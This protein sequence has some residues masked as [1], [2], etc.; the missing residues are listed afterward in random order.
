MYTGEKNVECGTTRRGCGVCVLGWICLIIVIIGGINWGLI[1]AFSFNLVAALVGKW[2]A[3]ERI[4]YII[5]GLAALFTIYEAIKCCRCHR[6]C[7]CCSK[8][9]TT[10][11]RTDR[12]DDKIPPQL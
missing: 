3:V 10:I 4:V 1:G 6:N 11:G 12:P 7:K 8:T 5:V 2:P 9:T